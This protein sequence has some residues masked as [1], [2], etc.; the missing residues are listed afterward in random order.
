[1]QYIYCNLLIY[2]E[3][4]HILINHNNVTLVKHNFFFLFFFFFNL[5]HKLQKWFCLIY[6]QIVSKLKAG[7]LANH[8]NINVS[9]SKMRPYY[10]FEWWQINFPIKLCILYCYLKHKLSS[11]RCINGHTYSTL[12]KLKTVF[13]FNNNKKRKENKRS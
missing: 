9:N 11:I 7:L 5:R 1:M 2:N 4:F 8:S 3:L 6:F 10:K 13:H 12:T